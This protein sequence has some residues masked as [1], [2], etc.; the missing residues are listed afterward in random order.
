MSHVVKSKLVMVNLAAI[1]AACAEMG[2]TFKE[3]QTKYS[4]Y[5]THV[6]DYPVP[7]GFSKTDLGKCEHAI[8]VPGTKWEIG[9]AKGKDAKGYSLVFDFWGSEGAPLA[10]A[11]GHDGNIFAQYY[12]KH[13]TQQHVQ[14]KLKG[15]FT[16][17]VLPNGVI[18]AKIKVTIDA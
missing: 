1:K 14:N 15:K 4:W 13:N 6:G 2:L 17:M 9:L 7:K 3:G 5:G 12:M 18:Q 8:G 10:K 16:S 11:V